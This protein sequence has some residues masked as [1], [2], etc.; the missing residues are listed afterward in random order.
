MQKV[1]VLQI[2][3]FILIFILPYLS[4]QLSDEEP[5]KDWKGRLQMLL[6]QRYRGV[7][8]RISYDAPKSAVS[9]VR[10]FK[11]YYLCCVHDIVFVV[12][13]I[14]TSFLS[15]RYWGCSSFSLPPSLSRSLTNTRYPYP[16]LSLTAYS[17]P[18]HTHTSYRYLT[19]ISIMFLPTLLGWHI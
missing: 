8:F 12:M 9:T 3:G 4:S 16:L 1:R 14:V 17:L 15:V 11:Y 13:S 19:L 7:A 2:T 5:V 6:A 10:T 18:A